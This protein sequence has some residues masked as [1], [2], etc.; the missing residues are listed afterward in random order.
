MMVLELNASSIQ[1][2]ARPRIPE[3]RF[4]LRRVRRDGG[5]IPP[6]GRLQ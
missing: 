6:P 3:A 5:R 2:I 1:L 4:T